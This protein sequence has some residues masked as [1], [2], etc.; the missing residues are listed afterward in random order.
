MSPRSVTPDCAAAV[1]PDDDEP[2][3]VVRVEPRYLRPSVNA[4][5]VII[6]PQRSP[7]IMK[8]RL[9]TARWSSAMR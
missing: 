4:N 5:R 6:M 8:R 1:Q 2:L 3:S 9:G 7:K